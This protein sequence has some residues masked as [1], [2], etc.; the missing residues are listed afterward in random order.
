[1]RK[2]RYDVAVIGAGPAGMSAAYE[3]SQVG[4]RV[5][6]VEREPT[7]GGILMQCIHNGFGLRHFKADLTGPEYAERLIE[8]IQASTVDVFLDTSVT[9]L[10]ADLPLP[11]QTGEQTGRQ[12]IGVSPRFGVLELDSEAVVLAMGCRERNRGNI[13]IPGTRPAGIFTAGFAQ[14]LVNMYG[15]LPGKEV[16]IIGSGDI[17]L[18]M[19][20]RLTWSGVKVKAVVEIMPYPG[21][22]VRNIV[23]CLDDFNIPLYLSHTVTNIFGRHRVSGVEIA[24]LDEQRRVI[25]ESKQTFECDTLLLS[26]GLVPE[27][28]LSLDAGVKLSNI[29]GGP[30]VD[31]D[32]M[33]SVDG[34]FACGN[35][36]HVHDLVDFVSEESIHCAQGV[37]RFLERGPAHQ[38]KQTRIVPGNNVRYLTPNRIDPHQEVM[39]FFRPLIVGRDVALIIKADGAVIKRKKLRQVQPSEMIHFVLKPEDMLGQREEIPAQIEVGLEEQQYAFEKL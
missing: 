20:R 35:V 38:Y 33:T 16:V 2:E 14:K 31:S 1:M 22:L 12:I 18:I 29:T 26:V 32:L 27:N 34:I 30:L 6:L 3:L 13:S 10:H 15:I 21:G 28:E 4:C 8:R 37:L 39:L 25:E 17:G 23:Q 11:G 24:K 36:L 9:E 19:A 5:A 7:V